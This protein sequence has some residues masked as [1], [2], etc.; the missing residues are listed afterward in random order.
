MHSFKKIIKTLNFDTCDLTLDSSFS[1][2]PFKDF[3]RMQFNN[4]TIYPQWIPTPTSKFDQPVSL[5]QHSYLIPLSLKSATWRQTHNMT[6]K[7]APS[8]LCLT[9]S[10]AI[11]AATPTSLLICSLPSQLNHVA[12][13][14]S[15]PEEP[16]VF[17]S[18]QRLEI[19]LWQ[20]AWECCGQRRPRT[21]IVRPHAQR[22]AHPT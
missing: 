20:R 3:C 2:F 1:T 11:V 13:V 22:Q 7:W 16:Q 17:S 5:I 21:S 8:C 6:G 15:H 4:L 12:Q 18:S 14:G 19:I 9:C 10:P